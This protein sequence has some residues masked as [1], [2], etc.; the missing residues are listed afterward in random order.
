MKEIFYKTN[1]SLEWPVNDFDAAHD[2]LVEEDMTVYL[3]DNLKYEKVSEDEINKIV[4]IEWNLTDEQSGYILL[5]TTD[6]L[7]MNVLDKISD[8]V[9]GQ[10]SDGLGEGF[11]QQPFAE[12]EDDYY[13]DE[14]YDREYHMSSFDWKTNKYKFKRISNLNAVSENHILKIDEFSK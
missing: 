4:K 8:W 10:N 2:Y 5:I 14:D 3:I 13:D 1:F 11:E 12:T 7:P 6:V 9:S